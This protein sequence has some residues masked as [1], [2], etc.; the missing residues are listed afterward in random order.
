MFTEYCEPKAAKAAAGRP[1]EPAAVFHMHASFPQ[2]HRSSSTARGAT[3]RQACS[4]DWWAD[5]APNRRAAESVN[6]SPNAHSWRAE[7]AN[8]IPDA[9]K[10]RTPERSPGQPQRGST[11]GVSA[12]TSQGRSRAPLSPPIRV[13]FA[14]RGLRS[15]IKNAIFQGSAKLFSL[16]VILLKKT[17]VSVG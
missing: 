10:G 16:L 12:V 11:R 4:N 6:I 3:D 2:C 8:A 13:T 7:G 17:T 15:K 5:D 1:T 9:P 14:V